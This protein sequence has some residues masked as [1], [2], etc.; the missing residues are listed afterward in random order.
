MMTHTYIAKSP[1]LIRSYLII[2]AFILG[3]SVTKNTLVAQETLPSEQVE[4]LKNFEAQLTS[5]KKIHATPKVPVFDT[6]KTIL[7]FAP[8]EFANS[9]E[10]TSHSLQ[11]ASWQSDETPSLHKG[12]VDFAIGLPN[13]IQLH[14]D[15]RINDPG[16]YALGFQ[17][18]HEE[19]S[20]DYIPFQQYRNQAA[21]MSSS[22]I[23]NESVELDASASYYRQTRYLYGK[24]GVDTLNRA[25]LQRDID[26][27]E[28]QLGGNFFMDNPKQDLNMLTEF[29]YLL[30]GFASSERNFL[31]DMDYRYNVNSNHS[32]QLMTSIDLSRLQDT[33]IRNLNNFLLHPSYQLNN[34]DLTIRL[35]YKIYNHI[36]KFSYFPQLHVSYALSGAKLQVFG[37]INGGLAKNNYRNVISSNPFVQ[38]RLDSLAN[39]E[40]IQYSVGMTGVNGGF[41]YSFQAGLKTNKNVLFFTYRNDGTEAGFFKDLYDDAIIPYF[42]GSFVF[43]VNTQLAIE[44]DI[45]INFYQVSTLASHFH[46]PLF[47]SYHKIS[48]Q[49]HNLKW[50][51]EGDY[52]LVG[53]IPYKDSESEAKFLKPINAVSVTGNYVISNSLNSYLQIRNVLGQRWERWLNYPG[54][55]V[56]FLAGIQYKIK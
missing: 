45:D 55:S 13:R 39:T 22:F 4:V 35:G 18:L 38:A 14:A 25:A 48:W 52:W 44:S 51:V 11:M 1:I 50:S 43:D 23:L 3:S 31:I 6:S 28:L 21:K 12:H 37:A 53:G 16:N 46:K 9:P 42:S 32:L 56:N 49:P 17:I 26:I 19:A 8:K 20:S 29:S 47:E 34:N 15:Y 10:L 33:M 27:I 36:D 41:R 7:N 54:Y 40:E 30:D 5:A 2:V 24:P